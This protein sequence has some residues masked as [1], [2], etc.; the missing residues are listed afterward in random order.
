MKALAPLRNVILFVQRFRYETPQSVDE[1]VR[2]LREAAL[3]T[4]RSIERWNLITRVIPLEQG[5]YRLEMR[6]MLREQQTVARAEGEIAYDSA[7]DRVVVSGHVQGGRTRILWFLA[8]VF[9]FVLM[10]SAIPGVSS[11]VWVMP[12]LFGAAFLLLWG[13][14]TRAQ[15]T[16]LRA[17]AA[18]VGEKPKRDAEMQKP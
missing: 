11:I 1:C 17:I 8:I 13:V 4:V 15:G 2:A 7:V 12:V 10:I 14:T 9:L 6:I 3:P 16:L 18:A 5:R